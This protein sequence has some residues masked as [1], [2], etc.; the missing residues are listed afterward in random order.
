MSG[1]NSIGDGPMRRRLP[2]R[3]S[4]QLVDFEHGGFRYTAGLGFFET[5][6][7]A[8]IFINV[9]GRSGSAIEVVARDAAILTSI[10]LQHGASVETIRHSL[11]RNSDGSASGPLG[12][13]LDLLAPA[14][15]RS[16]D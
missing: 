11:T 13:V 12:V 8:E 3:R 9:S 16:G 1:P 4:H 6:G 2:Q 14:S 5:G 15:D 7:L 10:C